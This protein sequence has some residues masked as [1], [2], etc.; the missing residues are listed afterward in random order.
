[1]AIDIWGDGNYVE[2]IVNTDVGGGDRN[3]VDIDLM[4]SNDSKSVRYK[5]VHIQNA[6][7]DLTNSDMNKSWLNKRLTTMPQY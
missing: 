5:L 3:D 1:M 2:T 4:N 7:I 6:T